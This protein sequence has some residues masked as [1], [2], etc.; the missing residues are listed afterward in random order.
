MGCIHSQFEDGGENERG[1]TR[2]DGY[3]AMG[4]RARR[5]REGLMVRG[6]QVDG[7]TEMEG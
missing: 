1:N 7:D 6:K 4:N 2:H 5:P 3:V